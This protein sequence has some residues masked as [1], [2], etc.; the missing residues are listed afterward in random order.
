MVVGCGA[1]GNEVIKNL[2][3]MEVGHL[4]IVDFDRVERDNLSRSV[5]F[6]REDAQNGARKVDAVRRAIERLSPVTTLTTIDGD[7]AYDVGLGEFLAS[8]VVIGC[9]D[10]RWA[11]YCINRL[12]MRAGVPWVDGGID[13]LE[14][15]ARVFIPGKNCYACNL[16]SEGMKDIARRLSCAGAVRRNIEEGKTPTTS[17]VASV[18]GAVEAQEAIKLVH[19]DE[20]EKGELTSLCGRMFY[21]DGEHLTTR[22]ATFEAYDADCTVHERWQP[23]EES[24]LTINDEAGIALRKV[25]AMT[26]S[27][28]AAISLND[29]FVDYVIRRADNMKSAVM[30]PARRVADAV[31][32]TRSLDTTPFS[33]LFQNEYTRIDDQFLYKDITLAQIGIPD[34]DV[35]RVTTP[36]GNRYIQLKKNGR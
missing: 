1:L 32:K 31:A 5:L 9:V 6:T 20:L 2:A 13:G 30:C 7:I 17:V 4:T 24:D 16:G 21:Y 36:N 35:L 26:C 27:K 19:R 3:L 23:I 11:R 25:R 18:I 28:E 22:T 8:D 12:C 14:G 29:Y 15:T 34:N 10:N 33:G